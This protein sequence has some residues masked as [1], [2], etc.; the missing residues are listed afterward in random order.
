LKNAGKKAAEMRGCSQKS[1]HQ[2]QGAHQNVAAAKMAAA[3]RCSKLPPNL[4]AARACSKILSEN[5]QL[6]LHHGV[7]ASLAMPRVMKTRAAW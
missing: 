1:A 6:K 4:R 5:M 3:L 2:V 7:G